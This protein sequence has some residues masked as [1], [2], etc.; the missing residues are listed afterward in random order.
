MPFSRGGGDWRE[1]VGAKF[2]NILM[3]ITDEEKPIYVCL[4]YW[5]RTKDKLG[6]IRQMEIGITI[7]PHTILYFVFP[8]TPR[9]WWLWA[10]GDIVNVFKMGTATVGKADE[11]E[12]DTET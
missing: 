5:L 2:F 9:G 12:E 4:F 6:W 11:E 7:R 1:Q 3:G 10:K 8:Y